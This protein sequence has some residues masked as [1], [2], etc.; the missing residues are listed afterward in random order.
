MCSVQRHSVRVV[1]HINLDVEAIAE[2]IRED[3]ARVVFAV[4]EIE[5]WFV[6]GGGEGSGPV[7]EAGL[8]CVCGEAAE[9]VDFGVDVD[10]HAVDADSFGAIH[11]A[12]AQRA[13]PLEA[14]DD[15][16]GVGVWE[17]SDEMVHDAAAGGHAAGGDDDEGSFAVVE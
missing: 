17:A 12:P 10:L 15:D 5:V 2:E 6:G 7:E 13:V 4:G 16:V 11:E 9:R 8:A 14:V 3:A 1:R